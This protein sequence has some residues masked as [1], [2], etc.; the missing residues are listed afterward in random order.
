MNNKKI[1]HNISFSM[2]RKNY[3]KKIKNRI[4]N[5]KSIELFKRNFLS[6]NKLNYKNIKKETEMITRNPYL[7]KIQKKEKSEIKINIDIEQLKKLNIFPKKLKFDKNDNNNNDINDN[8]GILQKDKI[9]S[10]NIKKTEKLKLNSPLNIGK[11]INSN[12]K[13]NNDFKNNQKTE[14]KKKNQYKNINLC[15]L[16]INKH[17]GL[18]KSIYKKMLKIKK[19]RKIFKLKIGKEKVKNIIKN[20]ISNKYS[21][22]N[23]KKCLAYSIYYS[24]NE[25]K[26]LL[27]SIIK[28]KVNENI[29]NKSNLNSKEINLKKSD[30]EL[31]LYSKNINL[32]N[33]ENL[34]SRYEI[35]DNNDNDEDIVNIGDNSYHE[36]KLKESINLKISILTSSIH[37][38]IQINYPEIPQTHEVKN[39]SP[40]CNKCYRIVFIFFNFIKNYITTYCPYCENILI[41][42][43]DIFINKINGNKSIISDCTCN[44]CYRSFIYTEKDNPF[45]LVEENN[46]KFIVLCSNCL[47]KRENIK[48]TDS[49]RIIQFEDLIESKPFIYDK[50]INDN[51]NINNINNINDIE[52]KTESYNDDINNFLFLIKGNENNINIIET[53]FTYIPFSL[54]EKYE[55]KMKLLKQILYIKKKIQNYYNDFNNFVTRIN[56]LSSLYTIIN[57]SSLKLYKLIFKNNDLNEEKSIELVSKLLK[58]EDFSSRKEII[59][60]KKYFEY[61]KLTKNYGSEE[62]YINDKNHAKEEEVDTSFEDILK[63]NFITGEGIRFNISNEECY[64]EE[65]VLLSYSYN[66]NY[67][68][69]SYQDVIIYNYKQDKNLYYSLYNIQDKKIETESLIPLIKGKINGILKLV[70]INNANDLFIIVN[71]SVEVFKI[72]KIAYYISNF[73][74]KPLINKYEMDDNYKIIYNDFTIC[75]QTKKRLMFMSRI[76]KKDMNIC[77]NQSN[78]DDININNLGQQYV[79]IQENNNMDNEEENG[80]IIQDNNNIQ[81][82]INNI[83]QLQNNLIEAFGGNEEELFENLNNLEQLANNFNNINLPPLQASSVFQVNEEGIKSNFIDIF[84][85][86][87]NYFIIL[88]VKI[89]KKTNMPLKAYFYLS[90]FD[91]ENLEENTKIEFDLLEIEQGTKFRSYISLERENIKINIGIIKSKKPLEEKNY[92][93]HFEN[94][95]IFFIE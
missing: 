26:K 40:L 19:N 87:E 15:S 56:M 66:I 6:G 85:I 28:E 27:E 95:E 52:K 57:L 84:K 37:K 33:N 68:S 3:L 36:S 50:I 38:T 30:K 92:F 93:F 7:K 20:I 11:I 8:F 61:N 79:D 62:E 53:N 58:C 34:K 63:I 73:R 4:I 89:M 54:K 12:I 59:E 48:K 80:D 17:K 5:K 91:F 44:K 82:E 43:P 31:S 77:K 32:G 90:L 35:G 65:I 16:D 45:V 55:S 29:E 25:N 1:L 81:N 86:D 70:L 10:S 24:G 83:I 88:L 60:I 18:L 74:V 51:N 72:K 71:K 2:D 39:S 75:I 78:I 41:Y 64:C 13:I 23:V 46:K 22:H 42:K 21:F 69:T 94:K 14:E 49:L 76:I 47:Q 9:S 67:N